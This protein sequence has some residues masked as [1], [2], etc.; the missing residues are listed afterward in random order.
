MN[1]TLRVQQYHQSLFRNA[2]NQ[3]KKSPQYTE[4][5]LYNLCNE[6]VAVEEAKELK[7][8]I[9]DAGWLNDPNSWKPYG[10][11]YE[12]QSIIG[13]QA[14]DPLPSLKEDLTNGT[15]AFLEWQCRKRGISPTDSKAPKSLL[16]ALKLYFGISNLDLTSI[17][18]K[19]LENLSYNIG[20]MAT[21]AFDSPC[22]TIFDKGIGRNPSQFKD[23][24]VS[25][26]GT[27]KIPFK[28]EVPFFTGLH[29]MG[30]SANL[31]YCGRPEEYLCFKL[32]I[33]KM[34]PSIQD[35]DGRFGF[36]I[37]TRFE[38]PKTHTQPT[39]MYLCPNG[40][41]PSFKA[42]NLSILPDSFPHAYKKPFSYGTFIKLFNYQLG[43]MRTNITFDF[44]WEIRRLLFK[45]VLPFRIYERR[46]RYDGHTHDTL[47]AGLFR[48]LEKD[49][50][51][52]LE[53]GFPLC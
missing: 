12:N 7:K 25:L 30:A 34:D 14:N 20:V 17:S 27:G 39:Y 4:K 26:P 5:E 38:N 52:F 49:R 42:K 21:G 43:H 28:S 19:E 24:F 46:K 45:P 10:G 51:E 41:I 47:V 2:R 53:E 23:T 33:S 8:L 22:I 35:A 1:N 31:T 11:Y 44:L 32:I 40:K 18:K 37:I 36:T 9:S 29:N 13:S 50:K 3:P 15:D 16:E 48:T 6:I